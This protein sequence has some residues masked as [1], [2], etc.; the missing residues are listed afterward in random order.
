MTNYKDKYLLW[1]VEEAIFDPKYQNWA[2]GRMEIH[3]YDSEYAIDEIRF[4]TPRNDDWAKFRN[5]YDGKWV[6]KSTLDKVTKV[7]RE[8]FYLVGED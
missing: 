4:F 5:G 6:D 1:F 7:I 2:G 8:K 3:T